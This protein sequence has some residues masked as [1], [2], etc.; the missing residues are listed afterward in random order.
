LLS[1]VAAQLA[2]LQSPQKKELS[3][4]PD[5]ATATASTLALTPDAAVDSSNSL[6]TLGSSES[7]SR[8]RTSAPPSSTATNYR[9]SRKRPRGPGVEK[10]PA[11]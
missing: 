11:A 10:R 4:C 5:P 6:P 7:K 8:G 2:R 1:K 9:P 3:P